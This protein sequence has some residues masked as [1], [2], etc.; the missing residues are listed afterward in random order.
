MTNRKMF[1]YILVIGASALFL[2]VIYMIAGI[3]ATGAV[4]LG[5]FV[6]FAAIKGIK[7][8]GEDK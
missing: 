5:L 7:M 3:V 8:I 1:G 4:T 2:E 6:A